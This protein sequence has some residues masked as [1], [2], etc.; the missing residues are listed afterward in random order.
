MTSIKESML[1]NSN[2]K[3]RRFNG[4][5]KSWVRVPVTALKVGNFSSLLSYGSQSSF[6]TSSARK[7]TKVFKRSFRNKYE[8]KNF[9][10]SLNH[11]FLRRFKKSIFF[12]IN[13]RGNKIEYFIRP[14]FK[15]SN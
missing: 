3:Y 14:N 8:C 4:S 9:M 1:L 10:K 12:R 15:R 5:S 6:D 2:Y 11:R 7:Y 13:L